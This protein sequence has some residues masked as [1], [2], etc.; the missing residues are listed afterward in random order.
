MNSKGGVAGGKEGRSFS[1]VSGRAEVRSTFQIGEEAKNFGEIALS[2]SSIV[3]TGHY[4][5]GS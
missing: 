3:E 4:D 2:R 5:S 1:R